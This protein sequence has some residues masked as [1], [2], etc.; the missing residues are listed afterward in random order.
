MPVDALTRYSVKEG[1]NGP[2]WGPKKAMLVDGVTINEGEDCPVGLCAALVCANNK[3]AGMVSKAIDAIWPVAIIVGPD[4]FERVTSPLEAILRWYEGPDDRCRD[5]IFGD[6][7]VLAFGGFVA[8]GLVDFQAY[9]A[10]QA[11]L[12]GVEN[13]RP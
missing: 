9:D 8:R 2:P 3:I 4:A 7:P 10:E 13:A 5:E 1:E 6:I 12:A 11:F